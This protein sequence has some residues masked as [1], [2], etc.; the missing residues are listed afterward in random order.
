M[1]LSPEN[2]K[3]LIDALFS[4][5]GRVFMIVDEMLI[6]R[7]DNK[8]KQTSTKSDLMKDIPRIFKREGA[9]EELKKL[10]SMILDLKRE[11]EEVNNV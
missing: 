8:Y 1:E 5:G 2:K 4:K 7:M 11:V 9:I 6:S 10:R 3:T